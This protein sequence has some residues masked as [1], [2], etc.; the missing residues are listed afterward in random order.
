MPADHDGVSNAAEPPWYLPVI[1]HFFTSLWWWIEVRTGTVN[2]P[3][4]YYGF[5]S[6]FGSDLGEVTLL[7][8]V[9]AVYRHHNCH[10]KGCWRLAKHEVAGTPYKVCRHCHPTIP[11]RAPTLNELHELHEAHR[12]SER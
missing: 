9:V 5:F 4:A 12:K 7:A 6:G 11:K 2:E 8:G 3:G 1:A 10:T